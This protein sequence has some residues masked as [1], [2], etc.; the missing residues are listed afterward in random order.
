MLRSFKLRQDF[1]HP[2]NDGIHAVH[3]AA[4]RRGEDALVG[5]HQPVVLRLHP[6]GGPRV[7]EHLVLDCRAILETVHAVEAR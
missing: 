4:V 5:E 2:S 6:V 3:V 1:I 7:P